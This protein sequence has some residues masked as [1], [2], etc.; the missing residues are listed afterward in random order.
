MKFN[1]YRET[2]SLDWRWRL[3]ASNGR[4]VAEGGEGYKRLPDTVRTMRQYVARDARSDAALCKE[5]SRL[6]FDWLG[7]PKNSPR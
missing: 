6:G 3:K 7:R 1:I 4:I 5:L 2:V